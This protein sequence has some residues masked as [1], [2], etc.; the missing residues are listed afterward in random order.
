[1]PPPDQILM[2]TAIAGVCLLGAWNSPWL[3]EQTRK[4]H[5]LADWLGPL[6]A[7]RTLR[8]TL[9]CGAILGALLAG[10]ILNPVRW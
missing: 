1:M 3:I 2:G 10:G 7:V 6:R 9:I 4:G 8:I 5:R